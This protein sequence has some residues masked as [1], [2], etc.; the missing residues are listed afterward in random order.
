[1]SD[2]CGSSCPSRQPLSH[3]SRGATHPHPAPSTESLPEA[4]YTG[5]GGAMGLGGAGAGG[6]N[7]PRDHHHHHHHRHQEVLDTKLLSRNVDLERVGTLY[8]S[9]F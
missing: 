3:P 2:E 6:R 8:F 4:E 5:R 7:S 9:L 1:M